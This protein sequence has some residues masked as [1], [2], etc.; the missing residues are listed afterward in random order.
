MPDFV[1]APHTPIALRDYQARAEAPIRAALARHRA[2][3]VVAPT[4][5]GKG[6]QIAWM[7]EAA[8]ANGSRVI[9]AVPRIELARQTVATLARLG[10]AAGVIAAGH[11]ETPDLPAQVA[12]VATLTRAQRLDRWAAW[13]PDLVLIDEAH[14]I[15]ART[16][17]A[18][19]D[20]LPYRRLIGFSA[21]PIRCDGKGLGVVFG[22]LVTVAT[23]R[24]L[25]DAGWLAP[26]KVYVPPVLP[27]LSA[28]RTRHGDY[29]AEDA[30]AAVNQAR[31][32]M[33]TRSSIT[34]AIAV[35]VRRSATRS[36]SR[37]ARR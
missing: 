29:V 3:V 16:W 32:F 7:T 15:R 31:A 14:H 37:T 11:L 8:I 20:G 23:V 9:V 1:A 27:D 28:V 4:G 5:S 36:T 13:G 24:E 22:E 30:A 34:A 10:V 26:L 6:V 18:L 17:R 35:A 25:T 33:A 2:I 12:S 21:T 19:V